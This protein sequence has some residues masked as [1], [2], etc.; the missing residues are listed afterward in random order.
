MT[1]QLAS[2]NLHFVKPGAVRIGF[3]T[4]VHRLSPS[5]CEESA[6]PHAKKD[7][8]KVKVAPYPTPSMSG[9]LSPDM[10]KRG[11]NP[12]H[13]WTERG[14]LNDAGEEEGCQEGDQ[15]EEVSAPGKRGGG[16]ITLPS[17]FREL[18]APC[19]QIHS[20]RTRGGIFRR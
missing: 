5:P 19:R 9:P 3:P 17:P 18:T 4:S 13:F 1:Q 15:E 8:D 12:V 14:D 10:L 16:P 6:K 11:A 20:N 2:F 7:L